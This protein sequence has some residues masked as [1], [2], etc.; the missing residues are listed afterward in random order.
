MSGWKGWRSDPN[1]LAARKA[2]LDADDAYYHEMPTDGHR[3]HELESAYMHALDTLINVVFSAAP[4]AQQGAP[5]AA[6]TT[7]DWMSERV[8]ELL[9]HPGYNKMV[10]TLKRPETRGG[11]KVDRGTAVLVLAIIKELE[12][13]SPPS[14]LPPETIRE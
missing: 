13:L 10:A 14:V 7:P 8:K 1:I 5:P 12:R 4:L 2:V 3:Q 11:A 9:V 6:T